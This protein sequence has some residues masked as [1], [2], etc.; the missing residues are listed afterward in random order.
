MLHVA[1]IAAW[2]DLESVTSDEMLQLFQCNTVGPLLTSQQLL[3]HGYLAR[4][5]T[6]ALMTS[7]VSQLV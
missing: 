2:T 1:G 6:L 5:S 7:K 3:K 4:G